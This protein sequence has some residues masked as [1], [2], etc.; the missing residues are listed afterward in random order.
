[1]TVTDQAAH[2]SYAHDAPVV[3]KPGAAERRRRL[4]LAAAIVGGLALIAAV[5]LAVI[6]LIGHP[7]ATETVRDIFIIVMAIESLVI[8]AAL[9][10][11]IVQVAQLTNLLRHEIRPILESTSET[12]NTLRGTTVFLS[13]SLVE[14][15]IKL[16]GYV[17]FLQRLVGLLR[18]G[19]GRK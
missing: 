8:G 11:L 10:V 2:D 16:G 12:A 7:A 3:E 9:V 18:V 14:P 15:V 1:M 4:I 5:V 17:A 13:E 6:F 19:D